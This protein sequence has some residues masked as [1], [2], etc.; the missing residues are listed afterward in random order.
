MALATRRNNRNFIDRFMF[1]PFDIFFDA[2]TP[3][4][5]TTPTLMKTDI[6]ETESGFELTVDLPGFKKENVTAELKDG[7]LTINAETKN[8]T[9][10][11]D[12]EGRFIR[13]E[14]FSGKCTRSYYVGEDVTEND[15]KAKFEDGLLKIDV[16]K[17]EAPK[18]ED[19]KRLISI[20]G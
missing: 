15:I 4:P 11:T 12:K 14:R 10:E 20:E 17:K 9:S 16:P 13:K 19:T 7:Y 5:Q 2:P 6:K 8:E 3:L 1:D 18:P